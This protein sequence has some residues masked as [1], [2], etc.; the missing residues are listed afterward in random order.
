M[1]PTIKLRAPKALR[2][3]IGTMLM[4]V[5]RMTRRIAR[6][7]AAQLLLLRMDTTSARRRQPG[8]RKK[9]KADCFTELQCLANKV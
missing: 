2:L 4:K 3:R 7:Q 6:L 8:L 1:F 5:R 9:G